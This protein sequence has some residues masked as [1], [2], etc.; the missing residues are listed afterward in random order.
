MDMVYGSLY[1]IDTVKV[2]PCVQEQQWNAQV[3]CKIYNN[4]H[5][6]ELGNAINIIFVRE[7]WDRL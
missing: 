7:I 1:A 5:N 6:K 3:K 4:L 2:P